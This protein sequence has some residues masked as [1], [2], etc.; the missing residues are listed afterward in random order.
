MEKSIYGFI[1]RYSL[2]QQVALVVLSFASF[3]PYYFWLFLPKAIVNQGILGKGITFPLVYHGVRLTQ[4]HYLFLLTGAFLLL[5]VVQQGFKYSINVF[6]GI[7]GERMLRRLRYELYGRVLRFPLGVFRRMS[8]GEIIPM[9]TVE[10]EALGGFI[11]NAFAVPMFQGG[12]F[13][14]SLGFLFVQNW[15]IALAALLIY[16]VQF[17]LVPKMQRRV[18]QLAKERVRS[19]RRLSDRVGESIGGI[20]EIHAHAGARRYLAEFAYRLG[21]IYWVRYEIYRRKFM[22]KSLNNLLQ[23]LGPFLFYTIGGYLAIAGRID[24]GTVIAAVAAQRDMG[25]PIREL[26]NYYQQQQDARIKYEQ[27]VSQFDPEGIRP[28]AD[29]LAEPETAPA[30]KGDIA[31]AN[32]TL[33]G[34][35]G[36]PLLEGVSFT[37]PTDR[38]L[39]LIGPS[40]GGR[41]ELALLLARLIAPSRGH[42]LVGGADYASLPETVTG[43]RI[44]FVDHAPY[45]FSETIAFNLF[46][47]LRHRPIAPRTAAEGEALGERRRLRESVA[48]GNSLDDIDADWTDYAAAGVETP[49]GLVTAG[50]RV[51][52]LVE[53]YDDVFQLGLRSVIDS[54]AKP[55][56]AVQILRARVNL[57]Q[58]LVET[59][60]GQVVESWHRERFNTNASV[61][62]NLMFGNPVGDGFDP[63]RLGDNAYVLAVLEKVGIA[64]QFLRVGYDVAATMVEI[65]A[66]LPPGHELFQQ[67]SFI[68]SDDLP[69]YQ[70]I[71]ARVPKER[72]DLLTGE[73]RVSLM[74]LPFKLVPSRHRLDV[75]TEELKAK[76]LDARQVFARDLPPELAGRIA[77]FDPDTYTAGANLQDNILFGKT[78]Y[79][80]AN[81]PEKVL[82]AISDVLDDLGLCDAV[83]EVGLGF[84]C[85]ISGG[86]LA[87]VQR[88]KLAI[89]RSV[90]KRPDILIL[91][92]ALGAFDVALQDRLLDQLLAEFKGRCL[93]GS[94][95]RAEIAERFDNLLVLRGGRLVEK[96]VAAE[97]HRDGTVFQELL[98][99][100]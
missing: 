88:Q 53:L 91:V 17:Y 1:L 81:A 98:R 74:S 22:I 8:P 73:A 36:A 16:P 68:S 84:D 6:Q 10:T 32:V 87:A 92:D 46:F 65:F 2:R 95:S 94:F 80:Q 37:Q 15:T 77:F 56:L 51:L 61:A 11:A 35:D 41:Q 45:I 28:E 5:V 42:L 47:G 78:A 44:G 54:A 12:M 70:E 30:L 55:D 89:A 66:D 52:R 19:V 24:V 75:C 64:E 100:S 26:L 85:G 90:M 27:I 79:G 93:I 83:A 25:S 82:G 62:E 60:L 39:A 13:L 76:I 3:V 31:V 7:S 34:E 23:Q 86:R 20:Q 14:V 18:N 48:S 63:E 99:Q 43:R 29:L 38:S 67:F 59:G 21:D 33:D 9:I 69:V 97:L 71:L 58:K 49:E 4:A 50:L 57:R 40:G 72:L 96:G